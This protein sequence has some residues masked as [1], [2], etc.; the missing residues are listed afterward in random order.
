MPDACD[1]VNVASMTHRINV[2][3]VMDLWSDDFMMLVP[4]VDEYGLGATRGN[5]RE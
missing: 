4:G 2:D 5:E 1:G 3:V